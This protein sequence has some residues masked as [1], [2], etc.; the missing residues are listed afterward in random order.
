MN[1]NL[2]IYILLDSGEKRQDTNSSGFDVGKERMYFLN[3]VII[4]FFLGKIAHVGYREIDYFFLYHILEHQVVK[5]V[6]GKV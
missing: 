5:G 4:T 6:W 3:P 2:N 1:D